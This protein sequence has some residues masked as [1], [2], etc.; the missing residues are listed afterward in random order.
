[1]NAENGSVTKQSAVYFEKYAKHM[2]DRLYHAH[3]HSKTPKVFNVV[4]ATSPH[5]HA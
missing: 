2:Q 4:N 1:M 5:A 3:T